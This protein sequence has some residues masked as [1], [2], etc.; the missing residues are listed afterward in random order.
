MIFEETDINEV[1]LIESDYFTDVRGSLTKTFSEELFLK[2][3]IPTTFKESFFSVSAK[4][5]IR[6]MHLQVAPS[7]CSKLVYVASGEILDVV[8]DLR[9]NSPTF[10]QHISYVLSQKNHKGL[11]VPE[12]CAHGFLSL[13]DNACTVYMQ[14]EMRD[15]EAEAGVHYDSFG[16]DWGVT[17]PI[18]SERDKAL[19]S[20]KEYEQKM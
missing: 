6:G 13:T 5:V 4:N 11:L 1:Y 3:R 12:G 14:T 15:V 9:A 7:E 16:M 8:V 2:N 10:G 18:L 20:L 17:S 19:P